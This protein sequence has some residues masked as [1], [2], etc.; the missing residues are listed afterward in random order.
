VGRTTVIACG[1]ALA[2]SGVAGC[3]SDTTATAGYPVARIRH[4]ATVFAQSRCHARPTRIEATR[5]HYVRARAAMMDVARGG[6]PDGFPRKGY[7]PDNAVYVV[8]LRGRFDCKGSVHGARSA[9]S[10]LTLNLDGRTMEVRGY[11]FRDP[12]MHV[13]SPFHLRELGDV[14]TIPV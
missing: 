8:Q 6:W 7:G 14:V 2:V 10:T 3:S 12:T 11:S 1:V 4:A 13:T 9:R 5:S